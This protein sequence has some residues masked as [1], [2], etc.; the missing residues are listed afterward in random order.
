MILRIMY[1][2][3][4]LFDCHTRF[5]IANGKGLFIRD[6]SIFCER[7]YL[8]SETN[9]IDVVYIVCRNVNILKE[10]YYNVKLINL[11]GVKVN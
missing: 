7:I 10:I 8:S 2:E 3:S 6:N 9:S 4:I 11:I 1:F 5:R